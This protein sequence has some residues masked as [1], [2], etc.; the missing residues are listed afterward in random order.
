MQQKLV[1]ITEIH[2]KIF[3]HLKELFIDEKSL[4]KLFYYEY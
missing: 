2:V 3:F 1:R 4:P